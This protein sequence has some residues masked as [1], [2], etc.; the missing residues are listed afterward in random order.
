[1]ILA[2]KRKNITIASEVLILGETYKIK[3]IFEHHDCKT[4]I[5]C[6]IKKKKVFPSFKSQIAQ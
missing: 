5:I 1:M 4:T 6:T 2:S 3:G